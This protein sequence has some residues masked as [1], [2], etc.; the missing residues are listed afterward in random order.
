[1]ASCFLCQY[2]TNMSRTMMMLARNHTELRPGQKKAHVFCQTSRIRFKTF[3][4]LV[5]SASFCR[6]QYHNHTLLLI[7]LKCA[8]SIMLQNSNMGVSWVVFSHHNHVSSRHRPAPRGLHHLDG[9]ACQQHQ[10]WMT[11]WLVSWLI[12]RCCWCSMQALLQR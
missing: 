3:R 7:L 2:V 1:M 8:L 9:T 4:T 11:C 6:F 5:E 10:M 12:R